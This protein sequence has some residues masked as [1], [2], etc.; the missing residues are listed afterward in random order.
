MGIIPAWGRVYS[1]GVRLV[2]QGTR[3]SCR[4]R[5][6]VRTHYSTCKTMTGELNFRVITWLDKG[7]TVNFTVTVPH[8]SASAQRLVYIRR[9]RHVLLW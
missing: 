6:I 3:S 9:L 1:S 4:T 7:L 8:Q 5:A 2:A